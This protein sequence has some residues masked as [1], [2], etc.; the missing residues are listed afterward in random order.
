MGQR[1]APT[2]SQDAKTMRVVH[3]EPGVVPLG[4]FDQSRQ[5]RD[6]AVHAEY[7]VRYDESTACR[8]GGGQQVFKCLEIAV[9]ITLEPR[10]GEQARI[11]QRSVIQPIGKD[12]V[13][14]AE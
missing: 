4:E 8:G 5:R 2:L 7:R 9:R 1:S 3:Q 6:I 12:G 14:A 13:I 11:V 10:A